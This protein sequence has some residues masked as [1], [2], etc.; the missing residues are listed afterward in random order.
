MIA[1][2]YFNAPETA[3]G[4]A[5]LDRLIA[6]EMGRLLTRDWKCVRKGSKV[7]YL[8]VHLAFVNARVRSKD[9]VP[10][11]GHVTRKERQFWVRICAE[12][13]DVRPRRSKALV[14]EVHDFLRALI[15]V[16]AAKYGG[17]PRV[18]ARYAPECASLLNREHLAIQEGWT[19]LQREFEKQVA[20]RTMPAPNPNNEG[21]RAKGGA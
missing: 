10:L 20:D 2:S 16:V 12:K 4:N 9:R 13:R 18:I 17:R 15:V 5:T 6:V 7:S 14:T 19:W 21:K 8:H 11:V 3:D 1:M